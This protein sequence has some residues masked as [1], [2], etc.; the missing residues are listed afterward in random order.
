MDKRAQPKLAQDKSPSAPPVLADPPPW[1]VSQVLGSL[2]MESEPTVPTLAV[3]NPIAPA[4]KVA[5]ADDALVDRVKWTTLARVLVITAVLAFAVAVDLGF[6]P[7]KTTAAP[8]TLL[9]QLAAVSYSV[10]FVLLLATQLGRH[11][12]VFMTRLAWASVA[13]DVW[14]AVTL[15]FV[16]DGMQSLFLFG[17]PLAVLNAA[18]LLSRA[19]AIASATLVSLGMTAMA[20]DQLGWIALPRLRVA[21][22]AVLASNK[23]MAP[24]EIATNLALQIAAVYATAVLSSHLIRELDRTRTKAQL[25]RRELAS[26]RVRYEDVVSSLPDGLLTVGPGGQV[27]ATNPAALDILAADRDALVG[28]PLREVLP[29]VADLL[30]GPP[31]EWEVTRPTVQDLSKTQQIA[32]SDESGQRQFLAVRVATL[33]DQGGQWGRV[34]VLRDVTEARH[35]EEMHRARERL[36]AIG[37]MATAVAH[38]IRNPL[39][40]ISGSV[41]LLQM[42]HGLDES[43]RALMA[44][45]IRETGQLSEWIGEFLDFARPRPLQMG[46]CDLV[47]LARDT[48]EAC[49]QD[50]GVAAAGVVLCGPVVV[51]GAPQDCSVSGDAALL[52][53]AIWNLL[54][55]AV[56]AVREVDRR[57]VALHLTPLPDEVE[58]AVQDSGYGVDEVEALRIFEPFYTT[59]GEAGTGLGLATVKRHVESHRGRVRVERSASLGG[60]CFVLSLPRRQPAESFGDGRRASTSQLPR[61]DAVADGAAG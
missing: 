2:D 31:G 32:R 37:A 22:L 29:E 52:R 47:E 12:L 58:L 44:I 49:K 10:S 39:A 53:Q 18:V 40:S 24:F 1:R 28:R 11:N 4:F 42:S 8:E 6:A 35:R 34:V 16:T 17:L 21:Y 51:D 33:R 59:K 55:N 25:Q 41:Q 46:P 45:V 60:A 14:L 57:E 38:E 3:P 50:P 23:S 13:A 30:V 19:G 20:L 27:T 36:A 26:L 9:Y 61:S 56:H 48:L 43:D 7:Q 5:A 54:I 15:V